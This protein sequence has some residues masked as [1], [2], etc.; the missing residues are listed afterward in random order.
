VLHKDTTHFGQC[1]RAFLARENISQ[2][3]AA[4][5]IGVTQ[6]AVAYYLTCA[7]IPKHGKAEYIAEKLGTTVEGIMSGAGV[8]CETASLPYEKI[9]MDL[10]RQMN[11]E[12]LEDVLHKIF[13]NPTFTAEEKVE[14]GKLVR[15]EITRRKQQKEKP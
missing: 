12:Q 4:A 1:L 10:L 8:I 5:R 2:K 9:L 6:Q 7:T 14:Y 11:R 13:D 3:A 15:D